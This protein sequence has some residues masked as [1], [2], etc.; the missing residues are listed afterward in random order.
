LIG[1]RRFARDR[2][3]RERPR[4]RERDPSA[5]VELEH[6]AR[7]SLLDV[8]DAAHLPITS[9]AEMDDH[10]RTAREKQELVLAAALDAFDPFPTDAGEL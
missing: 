6:G 10:C 2:N 1:A 7:I 8:T 4:I 5:V 3:R 9:H